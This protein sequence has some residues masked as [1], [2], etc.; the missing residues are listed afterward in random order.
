MRVDAREAV[1]SG[2]A[3]LLE[4]LVHNLVENGIRHNRADGGWL[5]VASRTRPGDDHVEVEVTNT[6]PIVP[7]YEIPALFEPFRRLN[8]ER[9]AAP[10]GRRAGTVDR[11]RSSPRPRRRRG[12]PPTAR[13]WSRRHS[14]ASRRPNGC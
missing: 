3:L 6:G 11:P 4:R 5:R 9:L 7:R 10:R 12:G 2:D 1:A 8:T 13:R 14:G